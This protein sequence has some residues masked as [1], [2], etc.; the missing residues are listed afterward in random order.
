MK[1]PTTPRTFNLAVWWTALLCLMSS[2]CLASPAGACVESQAQL[3]R[4]CE[5]ACGAIVAGGDPGPWL[6]GWLAIGWLSGGTGCLEGGSSE[7][8][9]TDAQPGD[10][11][12]DALE[13]EWNIS[14]NPD[15]PPNPPQPSQ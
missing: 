7:T 5:E 15:P 11:A 3:P 13:M 12:L 9:S 4:I 14:G 2:F 10:G 6:L 1:P 8:W